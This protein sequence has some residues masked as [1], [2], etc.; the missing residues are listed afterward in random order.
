MIIN[1]AETG[2]GKATISYTG[3]HTTQ[4]VTSGSK[5]YRIYTLTGSGTLTI[6][7][8]SKNS[9]IWACGGGANGLTAGRGGGGAYASSYSGKIPNGTYTVLIGSAGGTSSVGSL[10]SA[11]GASGSNGGTG[12]GGSGKG[13]GIAKYPFSDSTNFYCHCAGGGGG[14]HADWKLSTNQSTYSTYGSGGSNGS[15]GGTYGSGIAGGNYGGGKGGTARAEQLS[16][17]G[18]PGGNATFYGSG[19]GGGG[20][21]TSETASSDSGAGGAGYQGV[22]YIRVPA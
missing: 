5:K 15:N 20:Y 22:V 8:A 7:N 1:L 10:T 2:G 19:G 9:G 14:Q 11:N 6:K 4:V 3:N 21:A 18:A 12:G 13:D 17:Y 16:T